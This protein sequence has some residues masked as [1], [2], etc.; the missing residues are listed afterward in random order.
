MTTNISISQTFSVSHY[1]YDI[2]AYIKKHIFISNKTFWCRFL[3]CFSWGKHREETE[4]GNV[5]GQKILDSFWSVE[6]NPSGVCGTPKMGEKRQR[7]RRNLRFGVVNWRF[8]VVSLAFR[9][10]KK[11]TRGFFRRRRKLMAPALGQKT[12]AILLICVYVDVD[13]C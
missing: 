2:K 12:S 8:G 7:R 3:P 4:K 13:C 10:E 6:A 9:C 11:K 1:K 5:P